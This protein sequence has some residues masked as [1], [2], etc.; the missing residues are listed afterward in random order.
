MADKAIS[1]EYLLVQFQNF[2]KKI[3]SNFV[4]KEVGK[5]LISNTDLAQIAA[6]TKSIQDM[7]GAGVGMN[8]ASVNLLIAE[9]INALKDGVSAD[10]DT[11]KEIETWI[12]TEGKTKAD[13][14]DYDEN[15]NTLTLYSGTTPLSSFKIKGGGGG[16]D[17]YFVPPTFEV[18]FDQ[19][20]TI[21]FN[22]TGH[23]IMLG[24]QGAIFRIDPI[25]GHLIE[26]E[27]V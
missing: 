3:G 6:N 5:S 20:E 18:F 8:E 13:S 1:K 16:V 23:L 25:T 24:G 21:K 14:L 9:K 2:A 17:N 27:E 22:T 19:S 15:D 10:F 12:Q 11:M 26:G 4:Q 7:K